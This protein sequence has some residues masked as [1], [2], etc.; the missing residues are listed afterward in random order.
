VESR[1]SL[2]RIKR[3]LEG[4]AWRCAEV[5]EAAREVGS[6]PTSEGWLLSI[7]YID[8]VVDHEGDERIR[9]VARH[10]QGGR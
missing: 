8:G 4:I 9:K 2:P 6:S 3:T 1:L 5:R 10:G 7:I